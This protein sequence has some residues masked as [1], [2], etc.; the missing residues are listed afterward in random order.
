MLMTI[1]NGIIN[2]FLQIRRGVLRV[3][4]LLLL[5]YIYCVR[6]ICG[7]LFVLMRM[8]V[9]AR[10]VGGERVLRILGATVGPYTRIPAD[11]CIQNARDGRCDNLHIGKHVYIGPRCLFELA[12]S[13]TIDDD[14]VISAQVSFVTHADVGN[15]PLKQRFPRQEG[16]IIVRR[17]AWLG[18]NTTVLHGVTIGEYAVVGAMSLVNKNIRSNCVSLGI[19]CKVVKQFGDLTETNGVNSEHT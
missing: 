9:Y 1:F 10:W 18:V 8:A 5:L 16:P 13:I 14:V 11:V 4:C 7:R 15:R 19:P 2:G 12:S 17:G 6:F 3:I